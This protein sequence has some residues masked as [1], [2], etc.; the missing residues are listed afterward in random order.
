MPFDKF[1]NGSQRH[2]F[3]KAL[4]DAFRDIEKLRQMVSFG[5]NENLNV[6]AG[7]NNLRNTVFKL[8]DWAESNGELPELLDAVRNPEYGSPGN[9]KLKEFFQQCPQPQLIQEALQE[10]PQPTSTTPPQG[11]I[12]NLSSERGVD[13]TRLRDLLK[14]REWKEAHDQTLKVML[15]A[16]GREKEG[17]LNYDDIEKFPCTDLRTIDQLWVEYSDG[18]FGF[19]VQKRIWKSVGE[20]YNKFGDRVGWRSNMKWLYYSE[21]TFSKEAPAPGGHLP[22]VVPSLGLEPVNLLFSRAHT[23]KL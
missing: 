15:K 19:S 2:K 14:A 12:V 6:I 10:Q 13:Y 7:D 3:C 9:P 20:D 17:W 22:V 21:L 5:L 8:V 16:A 23:C 4:E 18:R 11:Q 1:E